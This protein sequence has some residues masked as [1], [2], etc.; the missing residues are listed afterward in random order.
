VIVSVAS[1]GVRLAMSISILSKL[2]I[3]NAID[4]LSEPPLVRVA[5]QRQ[6][7]HPPH[8]SREIDPLAPESTPTI[9]PYQKDNKIAIGLTVDRDISHNISVQSVRFAFCGN[10]TNVNIQRY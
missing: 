10:Y 6:S 2:S 1:I 5:C 7:N 9:E 3:K 4:S 8:S